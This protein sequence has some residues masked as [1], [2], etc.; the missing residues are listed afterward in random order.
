MRHLIFSLMA[1]VFVLGCN[2]DNT[3][4][5]SQELIGTW[6]LYSVQDLSGGQIRFPKNEIGEEEQTTVYQLSISSSTSFTAKTLA[7]TFGGNYSLNQHS[8]D[9]DILYM[10]E[11]LDPSDSDSFLFQNSIDNA[12]V[13]QLESNQL[14]LYTANI[15]LIFK[16]L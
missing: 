12:T 3:S 16:P 4:T 7:N 14:K 9:F 5:E 2:S 10:S 8:I 1:M 11:V 13:F 6:A 15:C